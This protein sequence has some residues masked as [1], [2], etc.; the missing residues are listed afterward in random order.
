VSPPA[1]TG[2]RL[3]APALSV[4]GDWF[5]REQV[6]AS[7]R[8]HRPARR[9]RAI[10]ELVDLAVP[11]L[12]VVAGW[13]PLLA[14]GASGRTWVVGALAVVVALELAAWPVR[15]VLD[16]WVE[17]GADGR[18]PGRT[19]VGAGSV[20]VFLC[21][22]LVLALGR[23]VMAALATV[24]ALVVVR[25]S[26]WWP[27]WLW[28]ALVGGAAAWGVVHPFVAVG[29][30]GGRGPVPPELP[31][32]QRVEAIAGR[33]GLSGRA[34]LS[35]RSGSE[36]V[37]DIVRVASERV[38]AGEG[39]QLVG[40][41]RG[42]RLILERSVATGDPADLDV[43]VAHELGH[44]RLH[45]NR[46]A[47][48]RL[49]VMTGPLLGGL[50]LVARWANLDPGDPGSLPLLFL[51]AGLLAVP[52]RL[53]S[54]RASRREE[55]R[56]DAYAAVIVGPATVAEHLRRHVLEVGADLA[57]GRW[58]RLFGG[59]PPPATRLDALTATGTA[60]GGRASW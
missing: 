16:G 58:D 60:A 5:T 10:G 8:M 25:S 2:T 42:R 18:G 4:A 32:V 44:W 31:L 37:V 23:L 13:G 46:A 56:A 24:G 49:A 1:G 26:A 40:I 28:L 27:L 52:V 50:W 51:V 15:A 35:G 14:G 41:G 53:V 43:V 12:F 22:F 34:A 55:G 54:A 6:A 45:H 30:V 47:L 36:R 9:A 21:S 3:N 57:P 7:E 20:G 39:A 19:A 38:G 33:A 48:A 17:L 59:H 11:V 29:L